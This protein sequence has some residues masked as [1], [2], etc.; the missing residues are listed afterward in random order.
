MSLLLCVE[1]GKHLEWDES[2]KTYVRV[3]DEIEQQIAARDRKHWDDWWNK[4]V[5]EFVASAHDAC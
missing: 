3:S 5:E 4:L 1:N 2:L